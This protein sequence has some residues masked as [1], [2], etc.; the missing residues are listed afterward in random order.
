MA[1]TNLYA[2]TCNVQPGKTTC[3]EEIQPGQIADIK[4]IILTP[5]GPHPVSVVVL[6]LSLP[7]YPGHQLQPH[8][9][10]SESH[11]SPRRRSAHFIS[12]GQPR[13]QPIKKRTGPD[14]DALMTHFGGAG[15]SILA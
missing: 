13:S 9:R 15:E 10:P 1:D 5:L 6:L 14:P 12:S 3:K 7:C 11:K 2:A 4:F 8:V